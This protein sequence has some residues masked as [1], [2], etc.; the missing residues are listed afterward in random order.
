[1]SG[2]G[3]SALKAGALVADHSRVKLHF[4]KPD[5]RDIRGQYI[6]PPRILSRP[7]TIGHGFLKDLHTGSSA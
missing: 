1:M 4:S 7:S 6:K 5:D 2:H 3:Y